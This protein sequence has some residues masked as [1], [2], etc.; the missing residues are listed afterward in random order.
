MLLFNRYEYNPRTD[1]IGK[2][3]FSRVYK[4]LDQEGNVAVAL[5]IY[6]NTEDAGG[7]KPIPEKDR[8]LAMDHPNICRYL[9]IEEMEKEDSF[10]EKESFQV[11]V[12]EWMDGGDLAGHYK[13]RRDL[14]ILKKLLED[15][16]RGL[17]YL[18]ANGIV[19][20]HVR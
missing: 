4:A 20:R 7:E 16:V 11:A 14:V 9:L 18:H 6:K 2:G 8:M 15:A 1:L 10:G 17:Q 5:K 12:L 19:H 13:S 3:G